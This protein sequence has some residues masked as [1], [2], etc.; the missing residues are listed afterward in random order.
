MNDINILY[1]EDDIML[2]SLSVRILSRFFNK[3]IHVE[4]G[5]DAYK[6]LQSHDD[7]NLLVTDITMP[8]MNGIQLIKGVRA[9][10]KKSAII[11]AVTAH[12]IEFNDVLQ[13]L[14]VKMYSKPFEI[15]DFVKDVQDMS[16]EILMAGNIII[17]S[18]ISYEQFLD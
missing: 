10:S 4:N 6:Y 5:K 17:D 8:V 1:A 13:K 11:C 18:T 7:I 16:D 9:T 14:N 2:A 3:V 12:N 15:L